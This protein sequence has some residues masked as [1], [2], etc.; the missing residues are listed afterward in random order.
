MGLTIAFIFARDLNVLTRGD[1]QARALGVSV[2]L[3]FPLIYI[4]TSLLTAAAV[5]LAGTVG[6]VGLIVPHLL[7]L[8]GTADH[9]VLPPGAVLL[10]GTCSPPPIPSPALQWRRCSYRSG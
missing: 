7:R 9:R 10:G 8:A 3:L 2:G 4:L 5:T 1:L 6:F